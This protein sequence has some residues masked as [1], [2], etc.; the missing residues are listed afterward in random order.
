MMVA[1]FRKWQWKS[2]KVCL[3][4]VYILKI[5]LGGFATDWMWHLREKFESRLLLKFLA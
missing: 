3:N 4:S 1:W 2:G 5:E